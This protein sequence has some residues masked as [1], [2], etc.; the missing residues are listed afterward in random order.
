MVEE[1]TE[2]SSCALPPR[3]SFTILSIDSRL[4]LF[5]SFFAT[6]FIIVD[7]EDDDDEAAETTSPET[8]AI[9]TKA[10]NTFIV[11]F[12]IF[13]GNKISQTTNQACCYKSSH[14]QPFA[15]SNTHKSFE[16]RERD[17]MRALNKKY[18]FTIQPRCDFGNCLSRTRKFYVLPT[19]RLGLDSN[20]E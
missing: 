13:L 12:F 19:K 7:D 4:L 6:F 16:G 17:R 14:K 1:A 15:T 10:A 8:R 18:R 11:S 20:C 5:A 2:P 3:R 9:H